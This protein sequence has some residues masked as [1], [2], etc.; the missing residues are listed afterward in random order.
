MPYDDDPRKPHLLENIYEELLA[1]FG[2]QAS[3]YRDKLARIL[4]PWNKFLRLTHHLGGGG[5][6]P[7]ISFRIYDDQES[8]FSKERSGKR[9][10][11]TAIPE[12]VKLDGMLEDVRYRIIQE[13]RVAFKTRQG[14]KVKNWR[15]EVANE[16]ATAVE[17]MEFFLLRLDDHARAANK[18]LNDAITRGVAVTALG[19]SSLAL[20]FSL[21]NKSEDRKP[22]APVHH[23]IIQ[24]KPKGAPVPPPAAIPAPPPTS[25]IA[26]PPAPVGPGDGQV[27]DHEPP[28][29]PSIY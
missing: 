15:A 29:A 2:Q 19:F 4:N 23:E 3:G 6:Q 26:P 1:Q 20:I 11:I 14:S 18:A 8:I 9:F 27:G 22:R 21:S 10:T 13:R 5:Q 25:G 16:N 24:E 7:Y 12:T 28:P 17:V